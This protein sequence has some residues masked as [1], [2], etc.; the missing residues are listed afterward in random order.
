MIDFL[1]SYHSNFD[2]FLIAVGF[3]YSQ[4]IVLKAG[5][6]SIATGGFASLGGYAVA[7]LVTQYGWT[8]ALAVAAA[9]IT[10]TLAGL[11][12]SFP[13]ARLRGVY[14]AIATLAFVEVIVAIMFYADG[15][16]NGA[17]G[18]HNIPKVMTTPWLL[19][20]VAVV[21][22]FVWT[23]G[24]SKIGRAFGV[25]RQDEMVG[26]TLGVS[27]T[28]YHSVAFVLSGAIGGVF[29]GMLVLY[30]YSIDPAQFGFDFIVA[31]LAAV[32]LG[33]RTSLA[34][35][36]VGAAVL[37][38]LPEIFRPLAEY[39][40]LMN[41]VLMVGI[42]LLVPEGIVDTLAEHR[43]MARARRHDTARP[44]GGT[45]YDVAATD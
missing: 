35:P 6:F 31:A 25:L 22:Y 15:L 13:L 36:L 38:I 12:L 29:G 39:R 7:I 20:A 33:G 28:R 14:Q 41:G 8:P 37:A 44:D 11:I 24:R 5:V 10:G 18:I 40:I 30:T 3:A 45:N 1:A 27:V 4:Q 42:I 26:M 21:I 43:R 2:L 19:I 17:A 32:V 23:I 9:L 34:G 16:T